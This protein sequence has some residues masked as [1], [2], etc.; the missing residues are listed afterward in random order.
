MPIITESQSEGPLQIGVGLRLLWVG[1]KIISERQMLLK[2]LASRRTNVEVMWRIVNGSTESLTPGNAEIAT[3]EVTECREM[4]DGC[5]KLSFSCEEH[6]DID[7]RFSCEIW[8]SRASYM[9]DCSRHAAE[10]FGNPLP[11]ELKA[12]GPTR[13][14]IHDNNRIRHQSFITVVRGRG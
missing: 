10:R 1:A 8:H 3:M 9:L 13:I 5:R 7:D 12:F 6:I 2:C 11:E 4:V 14:V